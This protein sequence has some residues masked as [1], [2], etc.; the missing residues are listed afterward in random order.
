MAMFLG[1]SIMEG[2]YG[3]FL[4]I[5]IIEGSYGDVF[6]EFYNRGKLRRCF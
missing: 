5:S 1:I 3:D 2:S 4:G 6:R